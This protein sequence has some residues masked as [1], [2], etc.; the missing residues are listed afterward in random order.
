MSAPRQGF[1]NN[2][3]LQILQHEVEHEDDLQ[4][5]PE[6]L[7]LMLKKKRTTIETGALLTIR[8]DL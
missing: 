5:L 7:D 1:Q 8:C 2:I 4:A 6:D 3:V